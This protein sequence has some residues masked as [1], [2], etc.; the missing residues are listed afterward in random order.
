MNNEIY[1]Q[2]TDR[3]VEL[4]EQ[5]TIPWRK[6]WGAAAKHG[7]SHQNL[8]SK[9][10]YRGINVLLL[11]AAGFS[12]P[13]WV[14]FNHAK[15]LGGNVKKGSK[16]IKLVFWSF[17]EKVREKDG[18]DQ[19]SWVPLLKSFTVFNVEQCEGFDCPALPTEAP[20]FNAIDE[21][22]KLVA[23]MPARPEIRHAQQRAFYS[24]AFD[25]VNMPKRESFTFSEEYYSTL[26]HELGHATG[27]KSRLN[28]PGITECHEFGDEDY[29]K[30][31]LVAEMTAAF[32][33]GETGIA[34]KTITN[35]A[36]YIA[37]WLRALKNDHKLVI[38]AASAA[39]KAADWIRN[40]KAQE[41]DE[42]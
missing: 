7:I 17:V 41:R 10:I 14:T 20:T 16:G 31:E 42:S 30:E 40:E 35:S 32:L 25:F 2:I 5:G 33:C 13:Y 34:P 37:S 11:S 39:Q 38:S 23:N 26:F 19:V 9:T 28:R 4:L 36:A 21:A 22:E 15:A 29:S 1:Q 18:E 24:G 27:H 6:S 3:I 12:S 8:Y